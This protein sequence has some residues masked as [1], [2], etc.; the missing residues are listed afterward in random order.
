MPQGP[1]A[2]QIGMGAQWYGNDDDLVALNNL[3]D[4]V[5]LRL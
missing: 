4:L 5:D 1:G 2:L 3:P